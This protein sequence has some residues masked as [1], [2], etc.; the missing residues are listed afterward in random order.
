MCGAEISPTETQARE[1]S[2]AKDKLPKSLSYPLKR[3]LL[4]AALRSSSMYETVWYVVYSRRRYGKAVLQAHFTPEVRISN[5]ASGK[6]QL[7]IY[8]VSASGRKAA[9]DM[10]VNDGLRVLCDWL[11]KTKSEGDAWRSL[12]HMFTIEQT[13]DGLKFSEE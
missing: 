11:A 4:D 7:T 13:D 12:V 5:W 8:A 9:E 6:I 2:F 3:S 10:L 1:Y